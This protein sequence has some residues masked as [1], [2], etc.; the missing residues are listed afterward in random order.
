MV[1]SRVWRDHSF[2]QNSD[3]GW[4]IKPGMQALARFRFE[5]DGKAYE[6]SIASRRKRIA[7]ART[8]PPG[9]AVL[10]SYN[11]KNPADAT[12]D[13]AVGYATMAWTAAGVASVVPFARRLSRRKNSRMMQVTPT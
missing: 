9:S 3:G 1:Q 10:V 7:L 2:H 6:P 4:T 8:Y 11:P 13:P 12:V 5:L